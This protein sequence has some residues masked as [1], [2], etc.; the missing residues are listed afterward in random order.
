MAETLLKDTEIA[1]AIGINRATV[2][3]YVKS[4]P[5]FPRPLKLAP[6]CTRFRASDFEAWLSSKAAA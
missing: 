3:R 4:D 1:E 6:K 5:T 2:W